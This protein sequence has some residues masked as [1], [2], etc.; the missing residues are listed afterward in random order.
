MEAVRFVGATNF[1]GAPEGWDGNMTS[2]C[3]ILPVLISQYEAGLYS[4]TSVWRPS[5]E[6]LKALNEGQGVRLTV[7]GGAQQPVAVGVTPFEESPI[8]AVIGK[9]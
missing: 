6:E 2:K 9:L 8:S 4:F 1:L 5:P 3:H 7:I